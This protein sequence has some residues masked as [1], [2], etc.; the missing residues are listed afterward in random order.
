MNNQTREVFNRLTL[1]SKESCGL[2]ITKVNGIRKGQYVRIRASI[3][4]SMMK[5]FGAKSVEMAEAFNIDH[6]SVLHHKK[7]HAGRY[8]SD[9]DYA[10]IFDEISRH[11]VKVRAELLGDDSTELP[12]IVSMIRGVAS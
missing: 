10:E 7:N 12:R 11:S 8:Q 5:H 6:T 2:D 3:I 4:V 9:D 1:F